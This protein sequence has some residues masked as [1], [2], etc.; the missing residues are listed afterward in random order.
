MGT[1]RVWRG[2]RL[3]GSYTLLS[4][5]FDTFGSGTC[6][7]SEINLVRSLAA[8]GPTDSNGSMVIY[9]TTD[10]LGPLD[11]P[12]TSPSGGNVWVTTNATAGPTAFTEVTQYVTQNGTQSINPNQ[13]PVSSVAID[14]SDPT[15]NTAYVTVMGF[16]GGAGHV[17]QTTNAG[18]T[19]TDFTGTGSGRPAG[20]SCQRGCG[21]SRR[22]GLRGHR[23]GIFESSTAS[24]AWTEVGPAPNPL[25]GSVGFLPNVAVTALGIF[26]P[27]EEKLL[28]AS[29][30]G[31]G[32]WQFDVS[33][34]RFPDLDLRT[35]RRRFLSGKPPLTTQPSIPLMDTPIR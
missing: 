17:W 16:T 25:G 28:R 31:R 26:N 34:A 9:A 12:L 14:S 21:G 35:V 24:P 2:P 32:V 11:G 27:L 29:T 15:G 23:R 22:H 33:D 5:N 30:Y 3:G 19:W 6:S 18:T 20:R 7:G 4:P 10:G 13:Y 8:G 1:C